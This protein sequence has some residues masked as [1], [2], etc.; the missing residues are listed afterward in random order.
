MGVEWQTNVELDELAAWVVV[1]V[2]VTTPPPLPPD[3]VTVIG[4]CVIYWVFTDVSVTGT[5]ET[6][7]TD[8]VTGTDC[9]TVV[10]TG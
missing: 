10:G 1:S 5:V 8:C 7:V 2:T 6:I 9:T 3:A 4:G